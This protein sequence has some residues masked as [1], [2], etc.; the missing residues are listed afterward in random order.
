[1][2]F[3]EVERLQAKAVRFLRD[4]AQDPDRAD[5]FEQMSVDEY[6]ERKD[7]E[8]VEANP[9]WRSRDVQG[10]ARR[11]TMTKEQLEE[12]IAELEEENEDLQSRLDSIM[13]IATPEED[14]CAA[15]G[16]DED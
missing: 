10:G 4:V 7:I 12:R 13:D 15:D 3:D 6:A 9:G 1:M 14:S 11:S 5:E 8:I 2:S 16:E